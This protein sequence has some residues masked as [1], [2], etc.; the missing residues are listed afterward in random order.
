MPGTL[1]LLMRIFGEPGERP[2]PRR[3]ERA[4]FRQSLRRPGRSGPVEREIDW[5]AYDPIAEAYARVQDPRTALVVTDLMAMAKVDRGHRV[6]DVG[7][8]TGVGARAAAAVVGRGGVAV[9]IDSSDGMLRVAIRDGSDARYAQ[10][11]AIDLPFP[12]RTFDRVLASFVLSHFTRYETALFDMLRVMK[13]AG[14]LGAA[15]WGSSAD[16]F[17]RTWDEVAYQFAGKEMLRDAYRRA[18]PWSERF[19]DPGSMK[20]TLYDAGMR[21]LVVEKREY[22]FE[23]SADDYLV[24]REIA[25]TGRFLHQMLGDGLW[26]TFRERTRAVFAER[27]PARFYD[28]RD[29]LLATGRK[30]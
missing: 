25:A 9:G 11:E 22:R 14:R 12:D 10:A 24:S 7:T 4:R 16:E 30:P 1:V 23:M 26:E 29:V 28:F 6:L 18:M 2:E 13:P 20:E 5:R 21:D 27:F 17:G 15:S 3:P 19:S 8:G